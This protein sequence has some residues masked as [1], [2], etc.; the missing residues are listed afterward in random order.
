MGLI[1]EY[2]K[3]PFLY[4]LVMGVMLQLH[5]AKRSFL[6]VISLLRTRSVIDGARI[7]RLEAHV[8]LD[9]ERSIERGNGVGTVAQASS[10]R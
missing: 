3:D 4:L 8:Q 10:R 5:L 9:S 7:T 1:A 2:I 6:R